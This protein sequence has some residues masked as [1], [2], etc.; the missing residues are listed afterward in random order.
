MQVL[1]IH[2]WLLGLVVLT[3]CAS[4]PPG[5]PAAPT[6]VVFEG[7]GIA[8]GDGMTLTRS[9]FAD[10]DLGPDFPDGRIQ[11]LN[12]GEGLLVRAPSGVDLK[13]NDDALDEPRALRR[14]DVLRVDGQALL[15]IRVDDGA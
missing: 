7:V 5:T 15:L 12:G 4:A 9:T 11:L 3:G 6:H 10:R 14:G 1:S 13:L 2:P 8:I